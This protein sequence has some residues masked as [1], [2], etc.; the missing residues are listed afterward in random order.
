MAAWSLVPHA[1]TPT[2]TTQP[3]GRGDQASACPAV[4]APCSGTRLGRGE[5]GT[6][7]SRG[8]TRWVG[9]FALVVLMLFLA[10]LVGVGRGLA[11]S[12]PAPN[13]TDW[14]LNGSQA[15][16]EGGGVLR[17]TTNG[18]YQADSAFYATPISVGTLTASFDLTFSAAGGFGPG[19]GATL[20][21]L[22]AS[23]E[24]PTAIGGDGGKL[25][26]EGL[27]GLAVAFDTHQDSCDPSAPFVAT[28]T[29]GTCGSELAYDDTN[30]S[31][32]A[33]YG[34]TRHITVTFTNGATP[35][36][37]VS[38]DGSVVL[39]TTVSSMP[40]SAYVGFTA[41]SGLSTEET[42]IGSADITTSG[43]SVGDEPPND[44]PQDDA[45][46]T[47]CGLSPVFR[48]LPVSGASEYEFQV[49]T[50]SSFDD[51]V[52]DSGLVPATNTYTPPAGTLGDG[53][54]YWRWKTDL[55]SYSDGKSFTI[56]LPHL[57]GGSGGDNSPRWSD[58]PLAV[59][60]QNG[61]LLVS[62]AGPSFP[63][64]TDPLAA[65][66]AYNSQSSDDV[67]LGPGW[68]LNAGA[69]SR[70]PARLI[71]HNLLSGADQLDA[72]E[73]K[74][75]D[76]GASCFNR[77]GETNRFLPPPGSSA[78]LVEDQDG[79]YT[80]FDGETIASYGQP[81]SASGIAEPTGI[82]DLSAEPGKGILTY[83]FSPDDPDKVVSVEDDS[84]RD[85]TF[86][87]NSLG[88]GDC[89]D[90]I[91]CV[92]GPDG[93]SWQYSGTADSG[94]GGSLAA[95]DLVTTSEGTKQLAAISYNGGG[96]VDEL[97]NANDLDASDASPGYDDTHSLTISYDSS[98]PKRVESVSDGPIGDQTPSS[99]TWSFGY[100]PGAVSTEAPAHDHTGTSHTDART[101]AGYTTITPPNQQG[102]GS[103]A[104]ATVYYDEAG[105]PI[106]R[107]DILDRTTLAGYTANN[108]LQW[109]EDE[110]GNPTDY[111]YETTDYAASDDVLASEQDPDAGGSLG[112][113]TTSYRYDETAIGSSSSAGP[114]MEGLQG[115]YYT[116]QNLAGI[117]S[118]VETDPNVD[119]DWTS[120]DPSGLGDPSDF[121]VAWEGEI[122][123]ATGGDYTFTT[124]S[125][126]GTQLT[127]GGQVAIDNW[128][129][130]SAS[131][132][133]SSPAISLE[134]GWYP[135][136]L[137]YY[138]HAGSAQVE[139]EWACSDGCSI[140]TET[141]PEADLQPAWLN[142][143]STVSPDGE[144][145]YGHYDQPWTGNPQYSE[146]LGSVDGASAGPLVT[147][148]SYDDYGRIAGKVMPAGNPS[149]SFSSASDET[150]GNLSN[151]GD[152]AT[153]DYGTSYSYY[154]PTDTAAPPEA[155]GGGSA[156]NQ[157]GLLETRSEHGLADTSYVYDDAGDTIA[158][159]DGA[160]TT[161]DHY[162]EQGRL[163]SE[164]AAGDSDPT[165]Y[166]YD[167]AG[168]LLTA[169][170]TAGSDDT[171]GTIT[172]AYDEAGRLLS[173]S[174]G[175]GNE[176]VNSYDADGNPLTR[177][178]A[179]GTGPSLSSS[180]AITDAT[181]STGT[182]GD[183][184]SADSSY[185]LWGPT[186]NLIVNG[187]AESNLNGDGTHSG[188]RQVKYDGDSVSR[189]A[190]HAKF[191]SEAVKV[192]TPG[193]ATGEGGATPIAVVS[194][195]SNYTASIWVY[196]TSST[197]LDFQVT[198]A[199]S[200]GS[201]I[202]TT[203][204]ALHTIPANTW[205]REAVNF[206]TGSTAGEA[207]LFVATNSAAAK[208]WW[209]DG[210]Q[211]EQA[212]FAS[213]YVETDGDTG[214]RAGAGANL[215][216][217]S[218]D[219]TQAW[220]AF[221]VRPGYA[222]SD[223]S[224]YGSD[225]N[226]QLF[227][228]GDHS[229]ST[230]SLLEAGWDPDT[231]QWYAT[232]DE[233]G[234]P[235]TSSTQSFSAST[236][237]T[238]VVA[239]TSTEI[240]I[241]V[242]G[243]AFN[244][245]IDTTDPDL[246]S[247]APQIGRRDD[248][249]SGYSRWLNGDI[250]WAAAGS[251]TLTDTNASTLNGYGDTDP[252]LTDLTYGDAT[253]LWSADTDAYQ[254]TVP[255][256]YT[257]HY[258]YNSADQ[259]T[260]ETGSGGE[261]YQ[262]FYD[263]R[264]DLQATQYPND[265]FSWT[266]TN[267]D[268]WTTDTYNRHGSIDSETSSPPADDNAIADYSYSYN[269]DGQQTEQTQLLGGTPSSAL[270]LIDDFNRGSLGSNWTSPAS[271]AFG[272]HA[273]SIASSSELRA[274]VGGS[275]G[276]DN[277]ITLGANWQTVFTLDHNNPSG[278]AFG[279]GVYNF[280]DNSGGYVVYNVGLGGYALYRIDGDSATGTW[281]D[282]LDLDGYDFGT[283]D[284]LSLRKQGALLSIYL[285]HDGT[286]TLIGSVTDTSPENAGGNPLF[287]IE[288][289]DIRVDDLIASD[290]TQ[291]TDYT[292]DNLGRLLTY[293]S[294][295]GP[296]A[297]YCYDPDSNR[298]Q[299]TASATTSCGTATY[300]YNPADSDSP[301]VDQL[302]SVGSTLYHYTTDGQLDCRGTGVGASCPSGSDTLTWDGLGRTSGATTSSGTTI[303]YQYDPS[304]ALKQRISATSSCTS[305]TTTTNYLFTDLIETN[306]ATT[307]TTS[308]QDSPTGN[309]ATYSTA[310][311]PDSTPSYLY[312]DAHGNQVATADGDGDTVSTQSYDP[313]G[314]P[315]SALP[316]DQTTHGYVGADDKQTDGTTGL[317]LMGARPYDPATGRFLS[318]DPIDGGSLNNYDYALQD[319]VD[320]YD[321]DGLFP[322]LPRSLR[323]TSSSGSGP[324]QSYPFDRNAAGAALEASGLVLFA[325]HLYAYVRCTQEA[326][327]ELEL[328]CH[329]ILLGAYA[330]AAAAAA[331][332]AL[333]RGL[334][335]WNGSSPKKPKKRRPNAT[336]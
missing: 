199:T 194:P 314:N 299:I 239:W 191:G 99:S 83:T 331:G 95:I 285:Q 115:Y 28:S 26:F 254:S 31:I 269:A 196:A 252:T 277:A 79:G 110:D 148:Y 205:T 261:S 45:V 241:S 126:E 185:G 302:T 226:E 91:V 188:W 139:L 129:D 260:G 204:Q 215:P 49:A 223:P 243:S 203:S 294:S 333:E 107:I 275:S 89:P 127:I 9:R 106:E 305:P 140:S 27:H 104:P 327:G 93:Q 113:P 124:V 35:A 44:E 238:V 282:L 317:V 142:Q 102:L 325:T 257:T 165:S 141:V 94:A 16:I 13:G 43:T 166:S 195:N 17:L 319:P 311:Q 90:A 208:S 65:S 287:D 120:S 213:P 198:R 212:P 34:H 92:S 47:S 253:T 8:K 171:A 48:A 321:L 235:A 96:L 116:N 24:S 332:A 87:W 322:G 268:G 234:T 61:N 76:G 303:C 68:V 80:Y 237:Q 103:P 192:T 220:V 20:T 122:H 149:P 273:L 111:S 232:R 54:Y 281:T 131:D 97:Q 197:T 105:N 136:E 274:S 21:L 259:L 271:A 60:E 217:G 301:G 178:L 221:R 336:A 1:L 180:N 258:S 108:Q 55:T 59:N 225:T 123:V 30:S 219:G 298:L 328:A 179:L 25:G 310:P 56:S 18:V 307:I 134:A 244:W 227:F 161:C 19:D 69:S 81:N 230:I 150:Y 216:V 265:T 286:W 70:A 334:P 329:H 272:S 72:V 22:D 7:P 320:G 231:Q 173:T 291:T 201:Y 313:W 128:Q 86:T 264:G 62:Y 182:D 33:L 10:A 2:E 53:S 58:G 133:V 117:P 98:S 132:P 312:Y 248:G 147:S 211:I 218:L 77:V 14:D 200:G 176:T 57:G 233:G 296:S 283:G 167:P 160:G 300:T 119:F 146:A 174:D 52:A 46:L 202:S 315:G 42:E 293:T 326:E 121:S 29:G 175:S 236:S 289:T 267:P 125:D 39:D 12:V 295:Y 159:S 190:T 15:E 279:F 189:D 280:T 246:S 73:A 210:A 284:Q 266:D 306:A 66:V 100:N 151:P 64:D 308:Y 85:L 262:F 11:D 278:K 4:P 263:D 187:G 290:P 138:G 152:P 155:C 51:V 67:G 309:L 240:G 130:Q 74:F 247:Y 222:S 206:D 288:S 84:G 50:D 316:S 297:Q 251:G 292:Y 38:I 181:R 270:P 88:S 304:G 255:A 143:T 256:G 154:G 40:S 242:N 172:T 229:S 71:D 135:I 169:S 63:T 162:D 101:A 6:L 276:Y 78:R 23:D 75:S 323:P 330:G 32:P 144:L 324:G 183:G 36:V 137:T 209:L 214:E 82:V 156:V 318:V 224:P 163:T 207:Y 168:N 3:G 193:S 164:Q 153:S 112:R 114:A 184:R 109:T 186:V 170:H 335:P 118:L 249:T 158:T 228:V 250:L 245:E 177:T 5:A 157:G 37:E 41:A 145:S